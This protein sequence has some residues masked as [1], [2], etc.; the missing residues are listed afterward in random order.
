MMP[1]DDTLI[2]KIIIEESFKET[3]RNLFGD[4]DALMISPVVAYAIAYIRCHAH[5]LL[6]QEGGFTIYYRSRCTSP[7][8][9]YAYHLLHARFIQILALYIDGFCLCYHH[10]THTRCQCFPDG[11]C[12]G[13]V[14]PHSVIA[15]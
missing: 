14:S 7:K 10:N 13:N 8:F 5:E 12:I 11:V 2:L 1:P 4:R 15:T 6:F 3:Y 9:H